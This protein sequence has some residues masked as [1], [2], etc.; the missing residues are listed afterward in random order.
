MFERRHFSISTQEDATA[1]TSIT[2]HFL[3]P[4]FGHTGA[5]GLK[6]ILTAYAL[7]FTAASIHIHDEPHLTD[8]L[9]EK[10]NYAGAPIRLRIVKRTAS[11]LPQVIFRILQDVRM[12]SDTR[13]FLV[14]V[15][16]P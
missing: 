12:D 7:T 16:Q 3:C 1:A 13:Y 6:Y 11:Q 14:L 2:N 5:A 8:I 4:P 9:T 15:R 10:E